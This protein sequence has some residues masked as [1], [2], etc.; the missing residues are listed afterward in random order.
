VWQHSTKLELFRDA[1]KENVLNDD[2]ITIEL[3]WDL[4]RRP[5]YRSRERMMASHTATIL[6]FLRHIQDMTKGM[7]Q[8]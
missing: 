4:D 1:R 8:W 5:F 7:Y 6:L 3:P 2:V